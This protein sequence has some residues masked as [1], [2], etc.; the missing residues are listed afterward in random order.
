MRIRTVV[1]VVS[2]VLVFTTLMG[3]VSKSR[4]AQAWRD[5]GLFLMNEKSTPW[6]DR[7]REELSLP[8]EIA[9]RDDAVVYCL[10]KAI[11]FDR[12]P[13]SFA[14]L[15]LGWYLWERDC[16]KASGH[17]RAHLELTRE[18]RYETRDILRK[19]EENGCESVPASEVV[20]Y[21]FGGP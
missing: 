3:C 21:W 17:L 15:L 12:E 7:V 14:H 18:D 8:E 2:Q 10:K 9:T 19:S 16:E 1:V 4:E 5:T 13:E 20:G 11:E 6:S